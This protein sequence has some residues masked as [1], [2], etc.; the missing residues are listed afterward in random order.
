VAVAHLEILVE[1]LSAGA[2]LECLLPR[3]VGD[4]PFRIHSHQCKQ[5]LLSHLPQRLAGYSKWIP[6]DWRIV[7]LVDRDRD[8]RHRL[9][10][11]LEHIAI[12]RGFRTGI[13]GAATGRGLINRLTIEEL[14]AWYFADWQA[15]RA[16]YPRVPEGIPLQAK[17]RQPDDIRGGT[18]EAFERILQRSGYFRGGLRK[19]EAARAIA[20]HL[21]PGRSSSPSFRAFRDALRAMLG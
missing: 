4:L 3:I 5:D 13:G 21:D 8:D 15:V 11:D 19:I 16:A 9:K 14:E 1:E 12:S 6:D 18:W 20:P 10:S 7:V 17:Y 2:A